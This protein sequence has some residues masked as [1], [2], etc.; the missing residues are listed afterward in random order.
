M[1]NDKIFIPTKCKVGFQERLDTYTKK[2]GYVIYH[3]SKVWRKE[4]SW[5]GWCTSVLDSN[6]WERRKQNSY[7]NS[8]K[9]AKTNYGYML[10][11]AKQYPREP[12]YQ[13]EANLTEEEYVEKRVGSYDKFNPY[14]GLVSK[15]T[16]FTPLEF[17]NTPRSGF[18]LNKNAGGTS[19]GWNHRQAYCRI[20]DP[21]GFEF[22]I[23][24]PNLLYILENTNCMVGKGLEGNFVYG[25]SGTEL[26]LVPENSPEYKEMVKF[27]TLQNAVA[28]K[29]KDLQ[30]G[31]IYVTKDNTEVTYLDN[32][33]LY[34][35]YGARSTGKLLWFGSKYMDGAVQKHSFIT[36]DVKSIKI[37]KGL[38]PDYANIMTEL[39]NDKHYAGKGLTFQ[40]T[41]STI[42]DKERLYIKNKNAYIPISF[43]KRTN[44]NSYWANKGSITYDVQLRYKYVDQG[45]TYEEVMT[46]YELYELKK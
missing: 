28:I 41:T 7:D 26:V 21:H 18:V 38:D 8:I 13:K 17:D 44:N 12:Y 9:Q 45:L 39:G 30:L 16:S 34:D 5:L 40:L 27:T 36:M 46:K 15:D 11:Q 14:I 32:N 29:K 37:D 19:S 42:L 23:T 25:W 33:Y 24:I 22:E 10:Q 3:D 20:Y 43:Y 1:N 35:Y 4:K 6:E 31:H 2:L